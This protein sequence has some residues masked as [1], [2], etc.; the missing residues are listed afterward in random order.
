MPL[1][2]PVISKN[3]FLK[4]LGGIDIHTNRSTNVNKIA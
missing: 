3:S 4:K 1:M 2:F